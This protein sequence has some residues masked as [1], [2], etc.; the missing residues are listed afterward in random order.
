MALKR[1]MLEKELREKKAALE[2]LRS[3]DF[4]QREKEIEKAIEEAA[5]EE[6]RGAVEEAIEAFE[7]EKRETEEKSAD[8]ESRIS[9]IETEISAMEEKE[10]KAEERSAEPKGEKMEKRTLDRAPLE[11]RERIMGSEETKAFL[12]NVRSA[13]E[14]RAVL[15]GDLTVPV[16]MLD[17]IRENVFRYS[18]LIN[19]VRLRTMNGDGR[20]T[21]LGTVPEAV[22][23]EMCAK[24]NE[25]EIGFNQ[26][27]LDGYKVAGYL[28]LCNAVKEDSEFDLAAEII[29]VLGQSIGYALD[30]AIIYG[31]G[32]ASKMPLGIVTRLAQTV[33]PAG[34]P[35]DAPAWENVSATNILEIPA[36]TT[37]AE[38]Y[39]DL[40]MDAAAT[41][42][43]YARGRR[44]WAM[45]S[46]T[47]ATLVAKALSVDAA[48]ALVSGVD[49]TMPVIGGDIDVL[50]FIP[51]GDIIGGYGELYLLG[52][53]RGLAIDMSEHAQFIEDNTIFRAKA[54]YDGQP[55][56]AKA[57]VAIN[58]DG[59]DVTTSMDFAPITNP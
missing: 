12:G 8:L 44:F 6:E 20:L 10:E 51:D 48:G 54:R 13:M 46:K 4:E 2:E 43:T 49:G 36:G 22:W 23:T 14:T 52:E 19:R 55:V 31:K 42:N 27:T 40:V 1:L 30:K 37:G 26:I 38:F 17:L 35:A 15:K 29:E 11:V 50:E 32:A 39:S 34:Y 28:P 24:I 58:I 33:Q 18:K 7:T 9:E 5:T 3:V 53:R 56:I 45:N 25:L 59:E 47:Y 16:V 41:V 21:V 57:F